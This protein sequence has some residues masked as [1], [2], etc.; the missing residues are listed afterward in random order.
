MIQGRLPQDIDMGQFYRKDTEIIGRLLPLDH[1]F[2]RH[3]QPQMIDLMLNLDFSGTND[4]KIELVGWSFI[5]Y[6]GG[7]RE[8]F[9]TAIQPQ[10]DRR[11]QQPYR[12]SLSQQ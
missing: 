6:Q 7:G 11:I 8:L 1:F 12:V 3:V 2:K 10:E 4:T 9:R 5:G